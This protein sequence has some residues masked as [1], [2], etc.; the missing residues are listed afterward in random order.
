[1]TK[2]S[3]LILL[4]PLF[5]IGCTGTQMKI[6]PEPTAVSTTNMPKYDR[7]GLQTL[8]SE[9]SSYGAAGNLTEGF[10][11]AMVAALL[12]QPALPAAPAPAPDAPWWS[13]P[14]PRPWRSRVRAA[15]VDRWFHS[16]SRA[17]APPSSR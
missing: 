1:M 2:K 7:V 17:A 14:L 13:R 10:V 15:A 11:A 3:L 4:A 5:L 9:T 16:Q 8:S 12:E 6:K